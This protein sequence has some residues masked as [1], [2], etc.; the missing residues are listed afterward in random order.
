MAQKKKFYAV[1][2]GHKPGIYQTWEECKAQVDGYSNADYKGFA[3]LKDAQAYLGIE[4]K[5]ESPRPPKSQIPLEVG[6]DEEGR[7][8][9]I[10]YTDGACTGNPGP[11]GYGTVL[12]HGDYRKE[13]S[14]GFRL[15]TNNRMEILACIVG[16]QALKGRC[17]VTIYS[18]SKYVVNAMTKSWALRWRRNEWKRKDETG[19]WKKALNSDLWA[20]ML[21]LC[22]KHKVKF[23][24]VRGHAGNEE[25]ERCDQLARMAAL[26]G[27]LGVDVNYEHPSSK[28]N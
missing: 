23:E 12:I 20:E 10:I 1:R 7:K 2:S 9:V 25:N 4:A 27:N 15:T 21:D 18:D 22:D 16:L 24:W 14:G 3:T 11:G 26:S 28:P 6:R 5:F 17:T 8:Q 19:E 13:L